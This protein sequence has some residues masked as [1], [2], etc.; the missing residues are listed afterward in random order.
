MI[1]C[2]DEALITADLMFKR[3][4]LTFPNDPGFNSTSPD[5]SQYQQ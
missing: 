5:R 4:K 3:Q 1:L 2:S